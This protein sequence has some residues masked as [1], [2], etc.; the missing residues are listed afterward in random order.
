MDNMR[1]SE[2]LHKIAQNPIESVFFLFSLGLLAIG[3]YLFGPLYMAH[4]AAITSSKY[5][6]Q[7]LVIAGIATISSLPGVAFPLLRNPGRKWALNTGTAAVSLNFL[8]L[9]VLRI[10][11]VGWL[12]PLWFLEIIISL[13][14]FVF[15]LYIE[16]RRN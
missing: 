5:E 3:I 15:R 4:S 12:P 2:L 9:G 1:V 16:A 6:L 14:C 13:S 10:I 11:A 7:E 8:F